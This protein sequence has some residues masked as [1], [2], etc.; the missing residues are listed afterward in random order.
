MLNVHITA[1]I[2]AVRSGETAGAIFP[3]CSKLTL[4]MR[5]PSTASF[6]EKEPARAFQTAQAFHPVVVCFNCHPGSFMHGGSSHAHAQFIAFPAGLGLAVE[7]GL[8]ADRSRR[9]KIG[10]KSV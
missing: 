1:F 6:A 7:A 9:G 2:S 3:P 4:R 10:V 8:R 5:I